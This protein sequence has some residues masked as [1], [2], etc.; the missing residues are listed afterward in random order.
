M[1]FFFHYYVFNLS[2]LISSISSPKNH[3][4][5]QTNITSLTNHL[6]IQHKLSHPINQQPKTLRWKIHSS[7]PSERQKTSHPNLEITSMQPSLVASS[8]CCIS[9]WISDVVRKKIQPLSFQP[10]NWQCCTFHHTLMTVCGGGGGCGFDLLFDAY[11]SV[12][13]FRKD[14][15][16]FIS[17]NNDDINF[18]CSFEKKKICSIIRDKL[19]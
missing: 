14:H 12:V 1:I 4:Q 6:P 17:I 18:F 19:I 8:G 2:R 7:K 13:Y 15:N 9:S 10:A 11:F 3:F 5:P 16:I